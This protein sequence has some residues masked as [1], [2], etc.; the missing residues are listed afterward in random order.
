[1][2]AEILNFIEGN[3]IFNAVNYIL[4]A[5]AA[6]IPETAGP[7]GGSTGNRGPQ[8]NLA[9]STVS[10]VG[11][12]RLLVPLDPGRPTEHRRYQP[13]PKRRVE[14]LWRQRRH[15]LRLLLPRAAV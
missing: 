12:E 8:G 1:M 14:G 13:G 9:N 5:Y 2:G 11:S 7:W 4:P 10:T 6:S 3:N 15:R